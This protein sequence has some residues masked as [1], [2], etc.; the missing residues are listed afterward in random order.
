MYPYAKNVL[1]GAYSCSGSTSLKRGAPPKR[2][3]PYFLVAESYGVVRASGIAL[4]QQAILKDFAYLV[5]ISIW[6]DSS[7]AI[8]ICSRS[9]L[10]KFRHIDTQALWVQSKVKEKAIEL[11]KVRGEC[12]PADLLTK[13]LVSREKL[14]GLVGLFGGEFRAGRPEAAPQLRRHGGE[15]PQAVLDDPNPEVYVVEVPVQPTQFEFD[16]EGVR[17]AIAHDLNVLPHHYPI[18]AIAWMFPEATPPEE[19]DAVCDFDP[20]TATK[21]PIQWRSSPS[22]PS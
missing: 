13:F 8:S 15:G 3:F 14:D 11:R 2:L 20:P 17:E 18:E 9:G 6:I 4:G 5:S 19:P 16:E 21:S 22:T 10:C 1:A 7:A 12:N